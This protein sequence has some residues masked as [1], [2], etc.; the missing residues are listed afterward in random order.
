MK[1]SHHVQ[2]MLSV[3]KN[4][5][6]ISCFLQILQSLSIFV[7]QLV[8]VILHSTRNM[9]VVMRDIHFVMEFALVISYSMP[10]L[11]QLPLPPH[12]QVHSTLFFATL[13]Y[14]N[15]KANVNRKTR[16]GLPREAARGRRGLGM[17][18]LIDRVPQNNADVTNLQ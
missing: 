18:E 14:A 5:R 11:P 13:C 3:L 16:E 9:L 7:T 15:N 4:F 1:R 12:D 10:A 2:N 8:I 6:T 17:F